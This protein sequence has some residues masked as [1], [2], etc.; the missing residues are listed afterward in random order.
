MQKPLP[1]HECGQR[2]VVQLAPVHPG[3]QMHGGPSMRPQCPLSSPPQC[4]RAQ[5][6]LPSD[7]LVKIEQSFASQ[8]SSQWHVPATHEPWEE[9]IPDPE[10]GHVLT[11]HPPPVHSAVQLHTP[12]TQLPWGAEQPSGHISSPHE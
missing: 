1:L 9:Q 5:R 3:M 8:P 4:L 7:E 6:I 10:T 2:G 11:L 12:A